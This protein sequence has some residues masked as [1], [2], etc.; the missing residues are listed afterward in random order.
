MT[1][2][3][4]EGSRQAGGLRLVR[5]Q[6]A[7]CAWAAALAA[8]SALALA[9]CAGGSLGRAALPQT[10]DRAD[11]VVVTILDEEYRA[12]LRWLEEPRE[13]PYRPDR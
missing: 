12:M 8:L 7:P 2:D 13:L 3:D 11:V 5:V 10:T 6:A 9:A 4:Q 1:C